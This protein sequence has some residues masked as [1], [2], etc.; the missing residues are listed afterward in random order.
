[1]EAFRFWC[2]CSCGRGW[3][4]KLIPH[5]CGLR[6]QACLLTCYR[7]IRTTARCTSGEHG[8][9]SLNRLPSLGVPRLYG[10]VRAHVFDPPPHGHPCLSHLA[11]RPSIGAVS[12]GANGHV[13]WISYRR[14]RSAHV[15]ASATLQCSKRRKHLG[16]SRVKYFSTFSYFRVKEG[17]DPSTARSPPSDHSQHRDEHAVFPRGFTFAG[18]D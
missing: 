13:N 15:L 18:K 1:M 9:V 11:Q 6:L 3:D 7:N 16:C 5:K 12:A 8:R 14:R 2:I 17:T 10:N 4:T